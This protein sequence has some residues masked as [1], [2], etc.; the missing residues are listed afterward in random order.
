MFVKN[1]RITNGS[2]VIRDMNFE[3]GLNL[4]I[5]DTPTDNKRQTGN[6][7]GKTTVLKLIYFCLGGDGKEIYTDEE[8]RKAVYKEVKDFLIN[9]EVLVTLTLVE[10]LISRN[11][12]KI[13]IEK[14]FLPGKQAIRRINGE[15]VLKKE[16]DE[17]LKTLM[18]P[19]LKSDKPTFKQ[20][21]SHNIRYTDESINNTLKTLN[22]YTRDVEYET[23]YLYLLGCTFDD[24][25]KKQSITARLSQE[26]N[27]KDRLEKDQTKN[28]YEVALDLI[29]N[30]IE[31]LNQKKSLLNI[32]E[33]FL[34]DLNL[35]NQTK[36]EINKSS[37]IISRLS[38]RKDIIVE[39]Q[40]EMLQNVSNID[41][42]Q[43]RILYSEVE[44]NLGKMT[45]TFE[46]LVNYHNKMIVEKVNFITKDLPN[47][48]NKFE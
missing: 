18:F 9:K 17:R 28:S 13:V 8:N 48:K 14:D 44:N 43:L 26:Q 35:L 5:D 25:D 20:L 30:E 1:L 39:A 36:Y 34:G 2:Q 11:S 24:A 10:D 7:V 19:N 21:I 38:I 40:K 41:V 15:Q 6:N 12:K 46:D 42:K 33:N 4:I 27:Y 45:K 47:L 32:N 37:S 22:R 16:F 31:L 23:L 29:E 3:N